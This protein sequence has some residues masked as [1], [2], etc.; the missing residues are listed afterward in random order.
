MAPLSPFN[1]EEVEVVVVGGG[2][3]GHFGVKF[4]SWR[5]ALALAQASPVFPPSI[6]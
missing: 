1:E 4:V 5:P 2:F 3:C 6:P